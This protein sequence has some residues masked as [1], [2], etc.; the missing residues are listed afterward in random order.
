MNLAFNA[1]LAQKVS[2]GKTK[3]LKADA[4]N[5]LISLAERIKDADG[6]VR[7]VTWSLLL[8]RGCDD[9]LVAKGSSEF[10]S[11][12]NNAMPYPQWLASLEP[13]QN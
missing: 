1:D 13:Q 4:V 11:A 12:V 8:G 6:L 3:V 7:V 5:T 2:N 10:E 9:L